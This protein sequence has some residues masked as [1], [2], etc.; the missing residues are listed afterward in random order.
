MMMMMQ[1]TPRMPITSIKLSLQ[2]PRPLRNPRIGILQMSPVALQRG[3]ALGRVHVPPELPQRLLGELLGALGLEGDV[4][5]AELQ[6]AGDDA[7]LGLEGAHEAREALGQDLEQPCEGRDGADAGR[8]ERLLGG[9]QARVEGG[10]V[11]GQG[12]DVAVEVG[13]VHGGVDDAGEAEGGGVQAAR[14]Q[15]GEVR[16]ESL[17]VGERRA[18]QQEGEGVRGQRVHG[19]E[20]RGQDEEELEEGFWRGFGRGLRLSLLQTLAGSGEPRGWCC[21]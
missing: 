4:G 3:R 10:E 6:A 19:I 20:E 5:R 15:V 14:N 12:G 11:L 17:K 8:L 7:V 2:P 16:Q 1:V 13:R 9:G 21:C 18:G